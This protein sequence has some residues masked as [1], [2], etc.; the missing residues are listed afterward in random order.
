MAS[1]CKATFP[2]P[3]CITVSI[4]VFAVVDIGSAS[5]QVFQTGPVYL[6]GTD[7][8]SSTKPDVEI[9]A[10]QYLLVGTATRGCGESQ[11]AVNPMHPDGIAVARMCRQNQYEGKFRC[12]NKAR[13]NALFNEQFELNLIIS[14]GMQRRK[15]QYLLT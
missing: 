2:K 10:E 13:F 4:C 9:V 15:R 14:A 3:C 12:P 8:D 6:S 5:A 1:V 11:V 7:A